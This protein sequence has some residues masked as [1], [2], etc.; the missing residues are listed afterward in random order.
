MEVGGE[1]FKVPTRIFKLI[2][3]AVLRPECAKSYDLQLITKE[4]INF[5]RQQQ[6][7][8]KRKYQSRQK[9][10]NR[11]RFWYAFDE[12]Y[13]WRR[14]SNFRLIRANTY[15]FC[16][17]HVCSSTELTA[18]FGQNRWT[19]WHRRSVIV[20]FRPTRFTPHRA[21]IKTPRRRKR[22]CRNAASARVRCRAVNSGSVLTTFWLKT[23]RAARAVCISSTRKAFAVCGSSRYEHRTFGRRNSAYFGMTPDGLCSAD[24]HRDRKSYD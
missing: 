21:W 12:K 4:I 5:I 15:Y 10:D 14:T 20:A 8:A 17:F 24:W 19:Q 2:L 6:I 7:L 9:S 23:K 1:I 16:R 3:K 13:P 18:F 11:H 22:R